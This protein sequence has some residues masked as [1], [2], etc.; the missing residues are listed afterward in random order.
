MGESLFPDTTTHGP[1]AQKRNRLTLIRHVCVALSPYLEAPILHGMVL[2][3]G[4]LG[5]V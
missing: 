5:D 4:S 1:S 3:G 2:G